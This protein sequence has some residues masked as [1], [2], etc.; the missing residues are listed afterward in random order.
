MI[1]PSKNISEDLALL[2]VGAQILEQLNN[3][4]TVNSVWDRLVTF[5]ESIDAPSNL[6]FWWFALALDLL[7]SL[8]AIEFANGQ[9]VRSYASR[10]Q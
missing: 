4:G 8:N 2:T 10:T 6:P 3:P 1:L 9:L 7:Y 5:R